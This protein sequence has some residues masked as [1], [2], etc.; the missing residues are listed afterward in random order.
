VAYDNF[1]PPAG[2]NHPLVFP[3]NDLALFPRENDGMMDS[4]DKNPSFKEVS[5]PRSCSSCR[6]YSYQD[7]RMAQA[8]SAQASAF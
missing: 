8:E 6:S 3:E 1:R 5:I 7:F 2:D 4:L